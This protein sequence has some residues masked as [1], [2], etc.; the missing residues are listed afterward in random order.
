MGK[1][2]VAI[3]G[4][5]N[6]AS[7][8]VQGIHYYR[9]ALPENPIPGL[10]HI[11]LG[12]IRNQNRINEREDIWHASLAFE[13]WL[14][15]DYLRLVANAGIERNRDKWSNVQD[16]FLL[17]GL[18]GSP[19]QTCDLDIGFKYSIQTKSWESPGPDYT[20]LAGATV[21]FGYVPPADKGGEKKDIKEKKG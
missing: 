3:I 20:I 18:I 7:S 8:L 11:N 14:L 6:C 21:W 4:V 15:K 17:A 5:G 1:I 10:M 13:F 19:S 9:D 16:A 12:Y 2:N